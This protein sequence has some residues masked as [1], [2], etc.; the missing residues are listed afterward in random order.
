MPTKIVSKMTMKGL[1]HYKV[2]IPSK[3]KVARPKVSKPKK[4]RR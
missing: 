1:K 3:P 4:P 2:N